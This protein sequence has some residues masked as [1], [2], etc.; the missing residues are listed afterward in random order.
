MLDKILLI[1]HFYLIQ[2]QVMRE[3][4][5]SDHRRRTMED[6]G[7]EGIGKDLAE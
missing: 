5:D 2:I 4:E 6:N 3:T 1:H 7:M